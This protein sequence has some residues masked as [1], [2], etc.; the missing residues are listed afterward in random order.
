MDVSYKT[1]TNGRSLVLAGVFSAVIFTSTQAL[2]ASQGILGRTS[3]SSMTITL[4]IPTK[5]KTAMS[6]EITVS[7]PELPSTALVNEA[8]PLCVSSNGLNNYTVT[9]TGTAD[10]GD[11]SLQNG[12]DQVNYDVVLWEN[13]GS[14]PQTLNS[15]EASQPLTS[16][17]SGQSCEGSSQL[18]L[19][20]DQ[21]INPESP[22]TGA[23]NLTINAN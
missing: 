15:G 16:L 10:Y 14:D 11:F 4:L 9:A 23:M 20:M 13:S 1:A 18:A 21:S 8:V 6:S 19:Q 3:S 5:L 2:S 12:A 17:A 22:V 7:N